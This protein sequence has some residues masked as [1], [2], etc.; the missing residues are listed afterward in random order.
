MFSDALKSN[1][2]EVLGSINLSYQYYLKDEGHRV[3]HFEDIIQKLYEI[4]KKEDLSLTNDYIKILQSF[5]NDIEPL[6]K[7]DPLNSLIKSNSGIDELDTFYKK[8]LAYSQVFMS[9]S[10]SQRVLNQRYFLQ[11]YQVDDE[12]AN[13]IKN[14][15]KSTIIFL[16]KF[17]QV[18]N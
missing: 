14:I 13:H 15:L 5:I 3:L 4:I 16:Q 18:I 1:L 6:I 9:I 17:C 11:F 2:S 10:L 7:K 8:G 12:Q